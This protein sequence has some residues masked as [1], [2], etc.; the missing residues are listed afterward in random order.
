MQTRG[1]TMAELHVLTT[2]AVAIGMYSKQGFRKKELVRGYYTYAA[3]P[4]PRTHRASRPTHRPRTGACKKTH[5]LSGEQHDAWHMVLPLASWKPRTVASR[6]AP[7][8][9]A[10]GLDEPTALASLITAGIRCTLSTLLRRAV[11]ILVVLP[12]QLVRRGVGLAMPTAH[13][14]PSDTIV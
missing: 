8:P 11:S 5:R 14:P 6:D 9:S 13:V 10:A 7:A 4:L 1:V 12:L 2:N 3:E